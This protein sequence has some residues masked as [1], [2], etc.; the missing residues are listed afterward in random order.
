MKS[1]VTVIFVGI[2]LWIT[3]LVIALATHAESKVLYTCGVGIALGL[4]GIRYTIRRARRS[5]I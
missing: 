2:S 1:A 3:G 4:I 5:G